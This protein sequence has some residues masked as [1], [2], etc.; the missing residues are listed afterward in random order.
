MS[1]HGTSKSKIRDNRHRGSV[2]A[3]LESQIENGS[4]LSVVS[5]YFTINAYH[6]LKGSLDKIE[7]LRFLF[8]EP[9][10]ISSIDPEKTEEKIFK[11]VD[12]GLETT[13]PASAETDCQSVRQVDKRE[14]R[15]PVNPAIQPTPREN[16]SH[17]PKRC[18][19][20]HHGQFQF[21]RAWTGIEP[22]SQ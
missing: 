15:D 10:F 14:G 19:E 2:G 9:N 13:Q 21:Y 1:N 5:A 7:G 20:S 12:A 17:R 6:A 22:A 11:I 16:V 3:F 18:R 4:S 8:G